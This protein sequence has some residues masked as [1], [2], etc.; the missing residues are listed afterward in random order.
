MVSVGVKHHVYLLTD[1]MRPQ[2]SRP[3][4]SVSASSSPVQQAPNHSLEAPP[5]APQHEVFMATL[6][7]LE[8][9]IRTRA[10]SGVRLRTQLGS[11]LLL[12]VQRDH[13]Y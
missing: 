2:K 7:C 12:Y 9:L 5:S 1:R 4:V 8:A 6:S 11:I 10:D 13:N 3:V